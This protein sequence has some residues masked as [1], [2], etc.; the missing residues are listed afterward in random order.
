MRLVNHRNLQ[1]TTVHTAGQ[2]RGSKS[3]WSNPSMSVV[4]DAALGRRASSQ[5]HP[6]PTLTSLLLGLPPTRPRTTTLR[7]S[8]FLP[9]HPIRWSTP[10]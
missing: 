3:A 6:Q 8:S 10:K 4:A 1:E 7:P 5:V 9:E 2:C